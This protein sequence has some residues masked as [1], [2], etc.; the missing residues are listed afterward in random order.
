MKFKLLE[1]NTEAKKQFYALQPKTQAG[2]HIHQFICRAVDVKTFKEKVHKAFFNR[3]GPSAK[4]S[5]YTLMDYLKDFDQ[6][7][8]TVEQVSVLNMSAFITTQGEYDS[9]PVGRPGS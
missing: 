4:G 7:V 1:T 9:N 5:V 8:V 6:V 2:P 3:K